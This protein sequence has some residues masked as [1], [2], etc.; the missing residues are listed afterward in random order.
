M[1]F[2]THWY[3]AGLAGSMLLGVTG[4][5][6]GAAKIVPGESI[7]YRINRTPGF[8]VFAV[9]QRYTQ[10]LFRSP[11]TDVKYQATTSDSNGHFALHTPPK[12]SRYRVQLLISKSG[13]RVW[14]GLLHGDN[15]YGAK[16]GK[17]NVFVLKKAA[18]RG[19]EANAVG[20]IGNLTGMRVHCHYHTTAVCGRYKSHLAQRRRYLKSRYRSEP[21]VKSK[22]AK[23]RIESWPKFRSEAIHLLGAVQVSGG[24]LAVLEEYHLSWYYQKYARGQKWHAAGK[25]NLRNHPE[26]RRRAHLVLLDAQNRVVFRAPVPGTRFGA[27]HLYKVDDSTLAFL[28]HKGRI[29][30][31]D[32]KARKFSRTIQLSAIKGSVYAFAMA[33]GQGDIYVASQKNLLQRYNA[34]G[35]LQNAHRV[36]SVHFIKHLRMGSRGA[37]LVHG[38]SV[39]GFG[40]NGVRYGD[41]WRHGV[42]SDVVQVRMRGSGPRERVIV[43]FADAMTVAAD[44]LW[45]LRRELMPARIKAL[46]S[47]EVRA[48]AKSEY[49][50]QRLYRYS[51]Q[52]KQKQTIDVTSPVCRA[53]SVTALDVSSVAALLVYKGYGTLTVLNPPA[54]TGPAITPPVR[55]SPR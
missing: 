54:L 18:S 32:V 44:S 8:S 47:S 45:V 37:C 52:G 6:V 30:R 35:V 19:Q 22:W 10:R 7:R 9:T 24:L 13:Y 55:P 5:S 49:E 20:S 53:V 25:W 28:V 4:C 15:Y 21:G 29:R 42:R 51:L 11:W 33:L 43:T 26:V 3:M 40:H 14:F 50:H 41:V 39:K 1:K 48:L 23:I 17:G 12:G 16:M 34:Q 36:T 46:P 27:T 31:F 2:T 38:T